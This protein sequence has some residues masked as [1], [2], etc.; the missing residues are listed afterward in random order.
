MGLRLR[1]G[2]VAYEDAAPEF[3]ILDVD[4]GH[5]ETP[6]SVVV[7]INS[8]GQRTSSWHTVV[9]LAILT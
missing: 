9:A 7:S 3:E 6:Q 4:R 8:N 1:V 5:V 2:I